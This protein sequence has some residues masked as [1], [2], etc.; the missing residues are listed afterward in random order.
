LS[1]TLLAGIILSVFK[2]PKIQELK[3]LFGYIE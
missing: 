1:F 3:N 2:N